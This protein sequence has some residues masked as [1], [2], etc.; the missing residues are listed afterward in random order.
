[1]ARFRSK[2][3]T[4]LPAGKITRDDVEGRLRSLQDSVKGSVDDKKSTIVA[5]VGGLALLILVIS[6]VL[7]RKAGR[8]KTTLVEIRRV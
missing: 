8:R 5:A 6:Y 1:M 3:K 4:T 7:G 2:T